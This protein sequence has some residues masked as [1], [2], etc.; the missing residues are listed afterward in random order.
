VEAR[1]FKGF[2]LESRN[3]QKAEDQDAEGDELAPHQY[4]EQQLVVLCL[5]VEARL[6]G[7]GRISRWSGGFVGEERLFLFV[8]AQRSL[9]K[10]KAECLRHERKT[11]M[12][13]AQIGLVVATPVIMGF[14]LMLHRMGVLQPTGTISAIAA[15]G[16]IA[17]ILF[18]GQ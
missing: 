13:D 11:D 7:H 16:L 15:S 3:D 12:T 5:F 8:G 4:P 18:F 10:D 6:H 1:E 2:Y 17:A 14:A 9:T